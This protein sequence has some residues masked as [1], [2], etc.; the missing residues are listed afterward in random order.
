MRSILVVDDEAEMLDILR[1]VLT[2]AGFRVV[3][4][5]DGR[6]ASSLLGQ[7]KIDLVLTDLLM[8][9]KDGTEVINELRKKHPGIPVVAM[10]GGGRMPRGEYLKIARLFGA[11][12]IL[13]KPFTNE[14]L[15]STIELLLPERKD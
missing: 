4:A 3:T 14:Q 15:L 1:Q 10:S 6:V 2:S 12:A 9:E 7:E 11:H 8:P 5:T 13:E